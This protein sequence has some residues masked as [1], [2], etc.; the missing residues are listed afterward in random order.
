MKRRILLVNL[1]GFSLGFAGCNE[2]MSPGTD[3]TKPEGTETVTEVTEPSYRVT[4]QRVDLDGGDLS[5]DDT[6][7]F[8]ELSDPV[9][10]E[11][12]QALEEDGYRTDESPAILE[13]DCYRIYIKYEGEYYQFSVEVAN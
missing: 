9:K 3:E 13:S 7:E 2:N 8:S 10:M 11:V 5:T 1:A 12:E 6:C 4:V